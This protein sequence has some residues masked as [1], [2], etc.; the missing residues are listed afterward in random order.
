[1]KKMFYS[2]VVVGCGLLLSGMAFAQVATPAVTVL[3]QAAINRCST[4]EANVDKRLT[5]FESQKATHIAQY[6]KARVRIAALVTKL[7]GE[8]VD[9]S[10][11]KVDLVT[12]N[13]DIQKFG[14]DYATYIADLTDTK[15]Y[16]CGHS[17]G[18]FRAKLAI[19]RAQL[20]VVHDDSVAV[21]TYW[22]QTIKPEFEVLKQDTT[23]TPNT[24]TVEGSN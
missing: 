10:Q 22:A 18:E 6:E 23:T 21:H 1:M 7:E 4:I 12:M 5:N 24:S 9:V 13:D 17:E 16:V 20:K 8:G 15:A 2:L 14:T 19:A 11:L 3:K